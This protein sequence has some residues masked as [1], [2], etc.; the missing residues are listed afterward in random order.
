MARLTHSVTVFAAIYCYFAYQGHLTGKG[1]SS[2][3]GQDV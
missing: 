3:G 1:H 2:S